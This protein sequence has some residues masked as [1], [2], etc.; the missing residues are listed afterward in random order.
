MFLLLFL[1]V[2]ATA[3]NVFD[4]LVY[5]G[6]EPQC[7]EKCPEDYDLVPG[8]GNCYRLLYDLG[9]VSQD[10]AVIACALNNGSALP[11][12]HHKGD[13]QILRD[14]LAAKWGD[15]I[16][17][18]SPTNDAFTPQAGF[19]TAYVRPPAD[20][21]TSNNYFKKEFLNMYSGFSMLKDL[22][23]KG[24]PNDEV[25]DQ[26]CVA[27]KRINQI[28]LHGSDEGLDVNGLDDYQCMYPHWAV[29]MSTKHYALNKQAY[30]TAIMDHVFQGGD[31]E[32]NWIQQSE[33][34]ME[35]MISGAKNNSNMRD[36]P[37]YQKVEFTIGP[38]TPVFHDI[39]E[40]QHI[41]YK[42]T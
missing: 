32:Q 33:L 19:W 22:W 10:R 20:G 12:F 26:V 1:P 35:M 16:K 37:Q 14:F 17:K 36:L 40:P 8:L 34:Q 4:N 7:T 9:P 2:L 29:C 15:K 25:L 5:E 11:T 42:C 28:Y 41:N 21:A 23:S 31:C 18:G 3:Q 27:R 30:N 6:A 24:Q 39:C 38:V 13:D